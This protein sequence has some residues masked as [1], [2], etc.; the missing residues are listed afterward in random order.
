LL[1]ILAPENDEETGM[2]KQGYW[3]MPVAKFVEKY[4]LDHYRVSIDAIREIT[5]RHTGEYCIRPFLEK[6]THK[7]LTVMHRWSLDANVHVRR[8]ASEGVRPRLPWARKLDQ[9]VAHPELILPILENL[10]DD[11]SRFVQKSVANNLND[12]LKDN[13]Q[14]GI[15]TITRWSIKAPPNRQWIIK[16]ALRNQLKQGN[17][18]ALSIVKEF[19]LSHNSL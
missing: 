15:D 12:I 1:A 6:H 9:F 5:K 14:V 18:T 11:A 2:F 4:G 7:T 19:S 8:L 16:H 13:Y 10:K 3:L 17:A